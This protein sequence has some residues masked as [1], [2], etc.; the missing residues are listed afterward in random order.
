MQISILF[1][2]T[3]YQPLPFHAHVFGRLRIQLNVYLEMT[4]VRIH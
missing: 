4:M 3:D 1:N 2:E